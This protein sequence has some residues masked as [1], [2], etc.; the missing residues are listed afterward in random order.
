MSSTFSICGRGNCFSSPDVD[1]VLDKESA[2]NMKNN[3][4]N[5]LVLY[6]LFPCA[7][8]QHLCMSST[9]PMTTLNCTSH[10]VH[11]TACAWMHS[12]HKL[13]H[14]FLSLGFS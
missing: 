11:T 1:V 3:D 12:S 9:L 2:S 10:T 6:L 8:V 14:L 7:I 4:A 13:H 5:N